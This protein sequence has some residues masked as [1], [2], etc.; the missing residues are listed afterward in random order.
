M[1]CKWCESDLEVKF[2]DSCK[3]CRT[4][5]SDMSDEEFKTLVLKIASNLLIKQI[6]LMTKSWTGN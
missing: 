4:L 6:N 1:K 2:L 5:Q 3:D